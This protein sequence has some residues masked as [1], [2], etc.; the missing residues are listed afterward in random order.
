[1]TPKGKVVVAMS[2]G[3]DSSVAA[4][5]LTEAGYDCVGVFMRL[6][7]H[8]SGETAASGRCCS[9]ADAADARA[10]AGMLK[11]PF[12][13]LNF[14]QEFDGIIQYFTDEYSAGRTP[15][16]CVMCNQHLKY[17]RLVEYADAIGAD[18]VCT[19]HYAR[20]Q[21]V[22]GRRM[23][24][25]GVDENKDQSYVLFGVE[26]EVLDRMLLPIGELSK[27]EV[28]DHARRMELPLAEK[29]DSQE[30]CFVPDDDYARLVLERH[31]EAAAEGA[32]VDSDGAR[33]GTHR[34]IAHY[35][36]GQRRGLRIAVG[37]PVYVTNIDVETNTVTLGPRDELLKRGLRARRVN[38]LTDSSPTGP[39]RAQAKIR[40]KHRPANA[41]IETDRST[42][43]VIFDEPQGAVTPG[44]AVVFYDGDVVLGGGW[45][46][47]A[48][49]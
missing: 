31:P 6:G 1:M 30:I 38:W 22:N 35:T 17:G 15:N 43:E 28:R 49:D 44:Q 45:I 3:V 20:I 5:L 8:E 33:L 11:I 7:V 4:G 32:V 40:Y 21:E 25:R 12:Y 47:E 46:D 2:G 23:L 41:V 24:A 29:P 18:Y 39:L 42:A 9:A 13:V 36:V 14:Q 16:P 48:L 34:G 27:D 37:S 19:G 26:G 10:V